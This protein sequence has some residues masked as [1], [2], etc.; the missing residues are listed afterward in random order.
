MSNHNRISA[1]MTAV[2]DD[3]FKAVSNLAPMDI[4]IVITRSQTI[5]LVTLLIRKR[6]VVS[7]VITVYMHVRYMQQLAT[8]SIG[9]RA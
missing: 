3:R 6:I 8:E 9:K 7:T 4:V 2:I 1:V 5:I